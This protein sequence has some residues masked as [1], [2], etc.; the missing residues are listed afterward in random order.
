MR[1]QATRVGE[2]IM[3]RSTAPLKLDR[4]VPG[5]YWSKMKQAWTLR[6]SLD[7]CR[8]LRHAVGDDLEIM[9]PLWSWAKEA[10]AKESQLAS[11]GKNI[12]GVDLERLCAYPR[13][14][15]AIQSRPYQGAA[16]AFVAQGRRVLIA[17]TPGLGKSLE[18]IAGAVES[19]S[20]AAGPYLVCAPATSL[21]VVWRR[22]LE[23]WMPDEASVWVIEG[24]AAQRQRLLADALDPRWDLSTT[25]VIVNIE[26]IRT[27]VW[28]ECPYCEQRW[29]AS[30]RP[31]ASIIDCGDD[32][33]RAL[34]IH[35][36]KYPELFGIKWGGIIMDECHRSLVRKSGN[37]TQTRAG[38]RLLETR[39]DGIRVA[40]SGTPMRGKPE[41]LWG[42][43]NWLRPETY[44]SYWNWVQQYW[45]VDKTLGF[46]IGNMRRDRMADLFKSL[47]GIM[48]RRTKEEVSPELPRKQ[49]MGTPLDP[50]DPESPVAVWLD[51]GKEQARAYKE[52]LSAGSARVEGGTL[53]AIGIL[54]EMTRLKQFANCYMDI[55]NDDVRPSLP[56]NKFD[57]LVQF[58]TE[59]NLIDPDDAPTGKVVVVSQ[60]TKVLELFAGALFKLGV[61][62]LFI[63]GGQTPQKRAE[64]VDAFNDPRSGF[65]IM[66]LNT[67]AGGVAI[68]LDAA[69]D[70]VF[71]D[72][73]HVPDEQEQAEDRINNRRPEEKVVAR[74]YWYL[75]SLGTIDEEITH[76]NIILDDRQKMVLDGRRGVDYMKRV[77][78]WAA[79]HNS[80]K[81][82]RA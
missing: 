56:S 65:N 23:M 38:A 26:M 77:Y 37:P 44:T 25:W 78:L 2:R 66:F 24:S 63:T 35:E 10:T 51:M 4:Q 82:A 58:L 74:R 34:T 67:T 81:K 59:R 6:L 32:P 7:N 13:M 33:K 48:I 45:D 31:R 80:Q 15:K 19:A 11:I 14:E 17:D 21:D 5:A 22:E 36:H 40:L 60:F 41:R 39:A 70:M 42:T 75:K 69:D 49:Y 73:T 3:V 53:N 50:A 68:T 57:W 29:L 72:E 27:K 46:E 47:D 18:A 8:A 55:N 12:S 1:V 16:A 20:Q 43:L 30:D 52:M 62:P 54:A 64:M 61:N 9:A 28:W 76:S 71:I 79:G